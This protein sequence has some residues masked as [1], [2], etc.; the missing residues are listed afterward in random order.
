MSQ[1]TTEAADAA[2]LPSP[3]QPSGLEIFDLKVTATPLIITWDET[4]LNAALDTVL[5]E[6]QDID[7]T[8]DNIP[9]IKTELAGLNKLKDQLDTARKDIAR[10]IKQPVDAFE[11]CVKKMRT[12]IIDVR[13]ALDAKVKALEQRDRESRRAAV[14]LMI[15]ATKDKAGMPDLDIPIKDRWLNKSART[16]I[17]QAEIENLIF[18]EQ[19]ERMR[20]EAVERARQDRARW[21]EQAVILAGQNY[22]F[23]L[24]VSDF[25]ACLDLD[26]PMETAQTRINAAYGAEQA[27]RHAAPC[28]PCVQ[29]STLEPPAA[30]AYALPTA[31]TG[32]FSMPVAPAEE[33]PEQKTLHITI[34]YDS[35]NEDYLLTRLDEL[36]DFCRISL[37]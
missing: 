8:W 19:Q 17:T 18:K 23:T 28:P 11:A 3:V 6:Y 2:L 10:R 31:D 27:R 5:A 9:A 35:R 13:G 29:P 22:G 24:P 12:R 4:A 30:P 7:V 14:Q 26:M 21:V 25:L 37:V 33:W 15:D 34:L 16:S 1:Q 32:D 36:R 20:A